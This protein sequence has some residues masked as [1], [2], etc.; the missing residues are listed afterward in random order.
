MAWKKKFDAERLRELNERRKLEEKN[1]PKA[2]KLTGK[3]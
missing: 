3:L 1:D 2:K